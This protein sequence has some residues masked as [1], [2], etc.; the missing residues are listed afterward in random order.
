[1]RADPRTVLVAN[2]GADLF[3]SDRMLLE[4]V[5]GLSGAGYR[6]VATVPQDGPLVAELDAAGGE[7]VVQ[8][9]PIL[10]K[11]LMN[12]R[13]LLTLLQQSLAAIPGSWRLIRSSGAATLVVN[14]ITPPLWLVLG[15]LAPGV[16]VVCHVHEAEQ[17]LPAPLRRLLYLPLFAA[18][19]VIANSEHSLAVLA[20]SAPRLARRAV[21][22]H[23]TV[24]G[25]ARVVAARPVPEPPLR[26]L[27]VGR[28]SERK[29]VLVAL[30]ALAELRARG[31][32]ARL[33]LVG[34]VFEGNEAFLSAMRD[35]IAEL[36]LAGSLDLVGF[37]ADVWPELADAD[38][39][40]V[41]SLLDES[42]GNTAVEAALAAR[43][44]VVSRLSGLVEATRHSGSVELVT[45]GDPVAMADAVQRLADDWPAAVERA[46]RTAPT[47]AAE[48]SLA[49]Y[50]ADLIAALRLPAAP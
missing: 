36:D 17:A 2:P 3:G 47:V 11:G 42:Y 5:R 41:P 23:N 24:P 19:R 39:V 38:L 26:L 49:R 21:V 12:P 22:V 25:P 29:G 4:T 8:P 9:T 50:T 46:S 10:R 40:L 15:R 33:R 43:P 6:V 32:A 45:P 18:H 16:Q 44:A 14:T 37:R 35:R 48:H 30:I 7:V 34:S 1:M 13:G 31:L 27:Y 28:L 20:G